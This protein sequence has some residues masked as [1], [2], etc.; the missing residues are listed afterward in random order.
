MLKI[1]PL[2]SIIEYNNFI[3][4]N[5]QSSDQSEDK[6]VRIMSIANDNFVFHKEEFDKIVQRN[7]SMSN[8]PVVPI[9]ING[10]LRT[11]KSFLNNLIIRHLLAL[12]N[13]LDNKLDN[14][15]DVLNHS[16]RLIDHFKSRRGSDTMTLGVWMFNKFFVYNKKVIILMDTQGIYDQQLTVGTTVCLICLSTLMSSYQIYNL[17]KRVQE[18][19]LC[20]MAYFSA[21]SNL[22]SNKD[23]IKIGQTLCILVRDW[24]NF[25]NVFDIEKCIEDTNKYKDNL[26]T[27]NSSMDR[28]KLDTR[29]R[30]KD[31]YDQIDCYLCPHP[32]YMVTEGNFS[33]KI[34]DIRKEFLIHVDNMITN[35]IQTAKPKRVGTQTLCLKE[36]S[37]YIAQIVLLYQNIQKD[38][39]QPST[40]LETT[41]RVCQENAFSRTANYYKEHMEKRIKGKSLDRDQI[42][43]IHTEYSKKARIYFNKLYVMGDA[44]TVGDLKTRIINMI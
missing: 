6:C 44:E 11:G 40:I 2:N 3:M 8:L 39:P 27:E 10:A 30:L 21:Y 17:D 35:I 5:N 15:S 26:L 23:K 24:P 12:D 32:G 41:E 14:K 36:L 16:S 4:Q 28:G 29:K 37:G 34:S 31:S 22:V 18:D 42:N 9:I 13:N 19:H 25:E 20:N 7:S 38:L 43:T 1:N 33:G